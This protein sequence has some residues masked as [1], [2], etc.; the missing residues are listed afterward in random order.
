MAL[1]MKENKNTK[2]NKRQIGTDFENKA[3]K[4]LE[5]S[6]YIIIERNFRNRIGE[7]DIIAIDKNYLCFVE[8]KERSTFKCGFALE[9]VDF[10]KQ[11]IIVKVA[12]H[13]LMQ[14]NFTD[15]Q[16][17]RFDVVSFDNN[18]ITLIKNAFLEV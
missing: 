13:Y 14:N 17:I 9:A 16:N 1:M 3:V 15:K 7:I 10:R 11:K 4:F 6:G 2:I 5:D 8:V 18:N 12:K